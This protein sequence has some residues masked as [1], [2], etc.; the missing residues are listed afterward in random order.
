V[1]ESASWGRGTA[2]ERA[3]R[4]PC[5]PSGEFVQVGHDSHYE[6]PPELEIQLFF[7]PRQ[8]ARCLF[9]SFLSKLGSAEP[10]GSCHP[11]DDPDQA[12]S[13]SVHALGCPPALAD[14]EILGGPGAGSTPA[15]AG[16]ASP[17]ACTDPGSSYEPAAAGCR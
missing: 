4:T 15:P 13:F 8:P 2:A 5:G 7:S 6:M 9:C 3:H 1:R 16:H 10:G 17:R 12:R 14:D 11:A